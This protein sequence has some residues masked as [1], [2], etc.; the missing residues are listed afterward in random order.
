MPPARTPRLDYPDRTSS[1]VD[2]LE[3]SASVAEIDETFIKGQASAGLFAASGP[4]LSRGL[5]EKDVGREAA[6]SELA[7]PSEGA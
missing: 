1:R 7:L 2:V 3:L 5:R 4:G 6:K